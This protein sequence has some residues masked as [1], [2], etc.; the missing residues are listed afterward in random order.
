[1][2]DSHTCPGFAPQ[3]S[4]FG[5][6]AVPS[7]SQHSPWRTVP[8]SQSPTLQFAIDAHEASQAASDGWIFVVPTLTIGAAVQSYGESGVNFGG[9]AVIP[10]VFFFHKYG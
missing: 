5:A 7:D 6:A 3:K 1:M 9:T 4:F 10:L 2:N 8:L